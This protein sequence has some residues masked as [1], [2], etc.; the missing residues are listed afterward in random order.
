[1]DRHRT[2]HKY[3]VGLSRRVQINLYR[4]ILFK[5]QKMVEVVVIGRKSQMK[6][7]HVSVNY[8]FVEKRQKPEEISWTE[9][10]FVEFSWFYGRPSKFVGADEVGLSYVMMQTF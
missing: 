3:R 5:F 9:I 6:S 10:L 8:K 1:M 4:S 7:I 2:V